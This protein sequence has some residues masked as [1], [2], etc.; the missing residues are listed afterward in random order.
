MFKQARVNSWYFWLFFLIGVFFILYQALAS[1]PIVQTSNGLLVFNI[2]E[3]VSVA[4]NVSINNTENG[5]VGNITQV[6]ITVTSI[7]AGNGSFSTPSGYNFTVN[8][9]GTSGRTLGT[10]AGNH[11]FVNTSNVL[12]WTNTSY[13][14]VNGSIGNLLEFFFFN[15]TFTIP[16]NYTLQVLSMNASGGVNQTNLTVQVNDTTFPLITMQNST[17]GVFDNSSNLSVNAI[18]INVTITELNESNI[19][20]ILFN[21]STNVNT[22]TFTNIGNRS[23]NVTGLFDGNFTY[24]VTVVDLANNRNTTET[25]T[26]VLDTT[27]P[28]ISLGNTTH[29]VLANDT[30]ISV[31]WIFINTTSVTE[32]NEKNITFRL[33]NTSGLV[34]AT[35]FTVRTRSLNITG[36][37]DGNYTYNVTICDIA[38]NCNTTAIQSIRLD[39][40]APPAP[41]FSCTPSTVRVNEVV[42][43]TC[44]GANDAVSGLNRS[45]GS[46]GFLF[47]SNPSTVF[48]GT[49]TESCTVKD[50][51]GN[52]N[53]STTTYVV[54]IALGGGTGGGGGGAATSGNT[55][56]VNTEQSKTGFTREVGANDGFKV[57]VSSDSSQHTVTIS[58]I[59]ADSKVKVIIQSEPIEVLL[60]I[61]ETKKVDVNK[62]KIYDISV[63]LHSISNGKAKVT[64]KTI[65]E[66]APAQE[67]GAVSEPVTEKKIEETAEVVE[68]TK[69][70]S[71]KTMI[72]II[73]IIVLLVLVVIIVMKTRRHR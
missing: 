40:N 45:F 43:C 68:S 25:R 4:L 60:G 17:N 34:N 20:F 54:N 58:Q 22:T 62:D 51:A 69:V 56:L 13:F 9:N 16:G 6:N 71:S 53:S 67:T 11:T 33:S 29:N 10:G 50:M 12:S 44:A 47:T 65:Q 36:L 18:F 70:S 15:V 21:T 48:T 30:N 59:T 37:G 35:T 24:N 39:T 3:D 64:V 5:Q 23:L 7:G 1:Q 32:I 61:G 26:V 49:F 63:T 57:T 8:T 38:N 27:R 31:N 19:T 42:T 14:V 2:N 41:S 52:Q 28:L 66:P 73:G 46:N 72:W 55:Y